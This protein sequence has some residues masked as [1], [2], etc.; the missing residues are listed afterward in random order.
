MSGKWRQRRARGVGKHLG[1]TVASWHERTSEAW[2]PTLT[3]GDEQE[4]GK[5]TE[6]EWLDCTDP[7]AMLEFVNGKT[8]DRK[9]RLFACACCRRIWQ[10]RTP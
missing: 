10:G 5:M 2:V 3:G 7:K 1:A 6:S 4:G 8:S 9:F